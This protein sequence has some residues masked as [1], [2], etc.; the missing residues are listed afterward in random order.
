VGVGQRV[1]D[2]EGVM[3]GNAGGGVTGEDGIS[4]YMCLDLFLLHFM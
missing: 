4:V 2:G 3:K 1:G